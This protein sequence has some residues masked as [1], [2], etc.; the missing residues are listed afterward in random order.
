ML[1]K[2]LQQLTCFHVDKNL[3]GNY[4]YHLEVIGFHV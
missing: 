2:G 4:L 1:P 3:N